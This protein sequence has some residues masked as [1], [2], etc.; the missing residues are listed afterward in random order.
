MAPKGDTRLMGSL[1]LAKETPAP[2]FYACRLGADIIRRHM[3]VYT[4]I[5]FR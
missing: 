5:C 2:A 1:L 3:L 4:L